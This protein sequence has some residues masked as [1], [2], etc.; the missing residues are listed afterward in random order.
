MIGVFDSGHGG[1][2]VLAALT[3]HFPT[4][5]FTYLG[6]HGN[7][8]YGGHSGPVVL[9]LTRAGMDRL[10]REGCRLV[11]VAC[12]SA[13]AVALRGIQQDWLPV[14]YPDR[15]VL[16]V[17]VPVVEAVTGVPWMH[18]HSWAKEPRRPATVGVFGTVHTIRSLAY[19]IEIA[20][21]APAVTVMQQECPGLAG[22]IEGD[23]DEAEL[24]SLVED[25]VDGLLAQVDGGPLDHVV[26]GCTHYP[27]VGHLFARCLPPG[28]EVLSQPELVADALRTY[29]LRRPEF[30][31]GGRRPAGEP[32]C[33][34]LTT[35][36][37]EQVGRVA[38]RFLG[39][40]IA[41]EAA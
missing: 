21:R 40:G 35:G 17:V 7:A 34:F 3:R 29:L 5:R 18:D 41:F 26:L 38:R 4:L 11:I 36:D 15:R 14:H 22:A 30:R 8:P 23:A 6:D 16:G 13:A 39:R 31:G 12:N 28:V 19:P 37:P 27:L 2:T 20:K 25:Y 32:P 24:A 9:D 1:L 10:F 33:R